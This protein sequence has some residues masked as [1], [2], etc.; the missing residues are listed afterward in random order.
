MLN[1]E[2]WIKT[3]W[4]VRYWCDWVIIANLYVSVRHT[5]TSGVSSASVWDVKLSLFCALR[6]KMVWII[7]FCFPPAAFRADGP[8]AADIQ[9]EWGMALQCWVPCWAHQN[10]VNGKLH[11]NGK[12]FPCRSQ[13]YANILWQCD[14]QPDGCQPQSCFQPA[15]IQVVR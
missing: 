6:M 2:S 14:Q 11:N 1:L 7:S 12:F 10:S 13:L 15:F 5:D 3:M 9:C 4:S 8:T